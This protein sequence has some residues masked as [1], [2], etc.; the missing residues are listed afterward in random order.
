M[1]KFH[2][3]SS[4][5]SSVINVDK[6]YSHKLTDLKVWVKVITLLNLVFWKYFSYIIYFK[7]SFTLIKHYFQY[8]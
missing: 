5:F 6:S 2:G 8:F 1:V 4:C 3:I 7:S